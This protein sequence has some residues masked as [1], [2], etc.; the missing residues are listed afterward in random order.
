MFW[1]QGLPNGL[2]MFEGLTLITFT[3]NPMWVGCWAQLLAW[4]TMHL[5]HRTNNLQK[6]SILCPQEHI[7]DYQRGK[8]PLGGTLPIFFLSLG[9]RKNLKIK[10]K[11]KHYKKLQKN[12]NLAPLALNFS[13]RFS[14]CRLLLVLLTI[15]KELF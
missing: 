8:G 7:L 9:F 5:V 13:I 14:L 11:K 1:A 15:S 10:K 6:I 4:Q 2:R 3:Y 12:K